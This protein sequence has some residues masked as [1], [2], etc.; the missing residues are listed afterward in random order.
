ML[1]TQAPSVNMVLDV[2]STGAL[3]EFLPTFTRYSQAFGVTILAAADVDNK[4]LL[5]A[6]GV[7]A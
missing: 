4:T 1:P 6:N 7:L 2:P 3:S 5:H